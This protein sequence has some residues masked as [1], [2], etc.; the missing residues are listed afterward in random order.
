MSWT[1]RYRP[2]R[3][4]TV[5]GQDV[6]VQLLKAALTDGSLPHLLF[7]GPAGTGKTTCVRAA[8]REWFGVEHWQ[9]RVLE[10]NASQ[11]RGIDVVRNTI[12]TF[13]ATTTCDN[14]AVAFKL[15][16]LDEADSMTPDAQNAL[17]RIMERSAGNTRFCLLCNYSAHIIAPIRSRCCVVAFQPV[18]VSSVV[19]RLQVIAETE[20]LQVEDDAL[21]R[22]AELSNGDMRRAVSVLQ[23]AAATVPVSIKAVNLGAGVIPRS[24]FAPLLAA[25]QE[26][27][28]TKQVSCL[29]TAI[30]QQA[31]PMVSVLQRLQQYVLEESVFSD[32]DR[33]LL[34]VMLAEV[35]FH[36]RRGS[37]ERLELVR[38]IMYTLT[39]N[40][41][42]QM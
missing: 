30:A 25:F 31:Y 10:L 40:F 13:A 22:V 29:A 42:K 33:A 28:S 20:L 26:Q 14:S 9:Q 4:D 2:T 21:E 36:V 39:R 3:L 11:E 7:H 6:A 15:V 17:K 1:E 38:V 5:C 41:I 35:D 16:I 12:K 27:L 23:T 24:V 8:A 18:S 19:K 34:L 32:A 37:S